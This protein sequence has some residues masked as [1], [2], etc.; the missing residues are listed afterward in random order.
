MTADSSCLKSTI[1][2]RE[3][4]VELPQFEV[5]KVGKEFQSRWR[6]C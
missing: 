6:G 3:V 2:F 4:L 5:L 1:L